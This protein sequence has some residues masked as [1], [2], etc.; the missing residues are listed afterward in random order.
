MMD[1]STWTW[2]Y[3]LII[4]KI[5]NLTI[6]FLEDLRIDEIKWRVKIMANLKK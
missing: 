4:Y 1:V 6:W 2:T 3:E 5:V